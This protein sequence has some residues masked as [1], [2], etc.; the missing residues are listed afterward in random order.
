MNGLISRGEDVPHY[1]TTPYTSMGHK[2]LSCPLWSPLR[3]THAECSTHSHS[4]S[5]GAALGLPHLLGTYFVLPLKY[6][7]SFIPL[8]QEKELSFLSRA[9]RGSEVSPQLWS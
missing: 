7:C 9:K 5:L 8:V 3:V 2:D 1:H 4:G 6:R